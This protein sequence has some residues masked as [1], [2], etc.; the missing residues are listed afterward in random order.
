[1]KRNANKCFFWIDIFALFT[2]HNF[3]LC[4]FSSI[5]HCHSLNYNVS[6]KPCQL[7][8]VSSQPTAHI[9]QKI[10]G[11]DFPCRHET[12]SSGILVAHSVKSS[13]LVE[14]DPQLGGSLHLAHHE[15]HHRLRHQ[16][17]ACA[18]V[19][20]GPPLEVIT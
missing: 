11:S 3:G 10:F 17:Q 5:L 16:V 18:S 12:T 6:V 14:V 8:E 1:M 19:F 2:H 4:W 13:Q 7:A 20:V 15:R 9:F